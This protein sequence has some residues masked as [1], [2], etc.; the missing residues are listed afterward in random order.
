MD[1][2]LN[3]TEWTQVEGGGTEVFRIV[4]IDECSGSKFFQCH[5]VQVQGENTAKCMNGS[6]RIYVA[7]DAGILICT[8]CGARFEH[9]ADHI[10]CE[11]VADERE[12]ND[13]IERQIMS[14]E[15]DS[16]VRE[17]RDP[18]KPR[19]SY[20]NRT[21]P[22]ELETVGQ[23]HAKNGGPDVCTCGVGT[24]D[25]LHGLGCPA[26]TFVIPPARFSDNG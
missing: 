17:P 18:N 15:D 7:P 12:D 26:D 14:G 11:E 8:D 2:V 6:K 19:F 9:F 20:R 3:K 1:T 21:T 16:V 24:R 13:A 25:M 10:V 5:H 4:V 23:M 22:A